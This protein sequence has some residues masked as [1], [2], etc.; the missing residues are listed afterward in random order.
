[1][2]RDLVT[3]VALGAF[4]I[5]ATAGRVG[6]QGT[7]GAP[8]PG[9]QGASR[10]TVRTD[11]SRARALAPVVVTGTRLAPAMVGVGVVG[12]VSVV[13]LLRV[14]PGPAAV[15]AALGTLPGVTAFDDQG[16]RL[17]PE[18]TVR[19]FLLSPVVG[20]PQGVS[21]FLDGVRINEPDAQ[22]VNFDLI[23]TNAL[24]D[25][26]LV[27]GSGALYGKNSLGGA[28]LLTT[29]RGT[30]APELAAE[31]GAGRFG[32][33]TTSVTAGG[34]LAKGALAGV[35]GFVAAS[36]SGETGWRD[37]TGA[38]TRTLFATVGRRTEH[39]D[40]T[41]ADVALSVLVAHDAISEAG[42]LPASYLAVNPRLNYTPGDVFR[43]DVVHLALRGER[44]LAGGTLRAN[45]FERR[46]AIEQYNG[47]VPP[48]NTDGHIRNQSGGGTV[49]W[50]RPGRL[51]AVPIALTVGGEYSRNDVRFRLFS[52]DPP[53][54]DSLATAAMVHEDD[55][56]LYAQGLLTLTPRLSAT[57]A[58]RGDY[59]RIPYRDQLDAGNDGINRY[60]RLSPQAGL[61]Y[62]IT[63]AVQSFV[64]Y[65]TG[66]RAPAPLELA[67]AAPDAPCAL[68]SALGGDPSLA[69]VTTRDL[70]GGVAW[71]MSNGATGR[72][73]TLD[74]TGYWTDVRDDIL[75]AQPT[76][77]QGYFVNVPRTRRAGV[78]LAGTLPL[79]A[80]LH[81]TAGYGLLAA[82]YQSTVQL[83]TA[84]PDPAPVRP[85]DR[86]PSTPRQSGRL[87]LGGTYRLPHATTRAQGRGMLDAEVAVRAVSS[88]YLRG[89]ESNQRSPLPGYTIGTFRAALD[90]G[91]IGLSAEID[92]LFD[93]AYASFGVL[94][95]NRLGPLGAGSP[96]SDPMVERFLTPGFPRTLRVS[97][98]VHA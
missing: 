73:A 39:A 48:P 31:V 46:N 40:G 84:D 92:N 6:A 90:L 83:A 82:T 95:P 71:T 29:R 25:A 34:R 75:F 33:W 64:A 98:R 54:L 62:A 79:P 61:A 4:A 57:L 28:L 97:V 52:V 12:T 89:D 63:P 27:R 86:F 53:G 77:T 66:F 9:A 23:P 88:Q 94:A 45:V 74:V 76:A 38:H 35:D 58:V 37:A 21:V 67:C 55:A 13:P 41:D 20:Q 5:A 7:G 78:E 17:Q 51:W 16:A 15:P 70:E 19:G 14:P 65:K 72:G 10:D 2:I 91:R 87:A 24:A 47:N 81:L 69:P 85:G 36:G 56:A 8:V 42:S 44:P 1:M 22:E 32:E 49:E 30:A 68:P 3:G 60:A 26:A 93:R 59:V 43:P 18:L 11:S 96:P 50:T 80:G